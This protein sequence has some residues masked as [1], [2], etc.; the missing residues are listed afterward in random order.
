M[1]SPLQ[2]AA[3]RWQNLR[4]KTVF[5]LNILEREKVIPATIA[6][7]LRAA[8]Y[9]ADEKLQQTAFVLCERCK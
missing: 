7:P 9:K 8:F 4:E 1:K 3:N 2:R 5:Q 6:E